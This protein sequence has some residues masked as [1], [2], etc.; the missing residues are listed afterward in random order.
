MK[1]NKLTDKFFILMFFGFLILPNI[2]LFR[3]EDPKIIEQALNRKPNP[4]PEINLKGIGKSEFNKVEDWYIDKIRIIRGIS[5]IWANYLYKL[6]ISAK[7]GLVVL[8]KDNWLFLGNYYAQTIDQYTGKNLPTTSEMA[9]MANCFKKISEIAEKHKVPYLIV[10]APDKQDIYPEFLPNYIV[11]SNKKNR[12]D[13]LT[14]LMNKNNINFLDLRKSLLFKKPFLEKQ[15]GFI[16]FQ[17][18][19]HWNLVG[20]YAG[21]EEIAHYV[22]N[23]YHLEINQN[24]ISFTPSSTTETDLARFLQLSNVTS[25]SPAVSLNSPAKK[26]GRALLIGDSFGDAINLYLSENFSDVL[27]VAN[28][29]KKD[30]LDEILNNYHPD[31]F[32]FVII[33]RSLMNYSNDFS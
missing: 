29:S 22:E 16:Y 15:F 21:Y 30:R 14:E 11:K 27:T 12:L 7:P 4:F 23:K 9:A 33:E 17:G 28:N 32:I 3:I 25:N 10:V 13:L 8:G 20:A 1:T 18:D 2:N 5:R 19:S 31:L 24:K 6:Y 26:S